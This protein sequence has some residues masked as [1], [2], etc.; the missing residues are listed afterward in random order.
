M[1]FDISPDGIAKY[2][3][4]FRTLPVSWQLVIVVGLTAVVFFLVGWR[5]A[6]GYYRERIETQKAIIDDYREK[7]KGQSP[8]EASQ[9]MAR[10]QKELID[11]RAELEKVKTRMATPGVTGPPLPSTA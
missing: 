11:L 5:I 4:I 8:A 6:L 9:Q 1:G 10:N 3:P 7:L 2:I